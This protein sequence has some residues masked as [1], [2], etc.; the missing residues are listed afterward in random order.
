MKNIEELYTCFTKIGKNGYLVVPRSLLEESL[1]EQE[2]FTVGQAYL[3]LFMRCEFC[4]RKG[5]GALK[6]G[7]V[8]FTLGELAERFGWKKGTVRG[9]LRELK[10]L[11]LVRM[12]VVP[13][14]KIKLTLCFYEALTGGHGRPVE[15]REKEEFLHFWRTYYDLLER[16]GTDL[17]AA[18]A[19]WN[20]MTEEEHRLA[21]QNMER[22]FRSL[23]DI[24]YVR[25]AC[26]YLRLK[27]FLQPE[28]VEGT[29]DV[30]S[31]TIG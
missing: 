17:Y 23:N 31:Y 9:F 10:E 5:K 22:Y 27:T 18:L 24:R 8:A 28:N 19:E 2:S 1:K 13:G 30:L 20:R 29:A 21:V 7:Q 6:R 26:N 15:E 11:G 4:N 14:V 16:E 3:Y 12:E 25:T